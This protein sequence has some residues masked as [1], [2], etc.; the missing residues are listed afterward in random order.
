MKS[1]L[2]FQ[3]IKKDFRAHLKDLSLVIVCEALLIAILYACVAGLLMF[4]G[5][6]SADLLTQNEEVSRMFLSSGEIFL[7]CGLI[8]IINI[9][10]CYLGK[11][12]PDYMLLKR[13]GIMRK[14]LKK[15]VAFEAGITYVISLFIGLALGVLIQR[16]L[17]TIVV[18]LIDIDFQTTKVSILVFPAIAVFMLVFYGIGYLLVSELESDFLLI[19]NSQETSRIEKLKGRFGIPKIILGIFLCIFSAFSY[20]KIYNHEAV[21]LIILFFIGIYLVLRNIGAYILLYIKN[22]KPRTYYR[23]LL[24]NNKL[25]YRPNTTTRYILFFSFVGF[26]AYSFFGFQAVSIKNAISTEN[27]YPYDFVCVSNDD[28]KELFNTL[29]MDYGASVVEYPMV[30]V[31]SQ[32]KTERLEMYREKR[33]QGQQIGISETTYHQ[34]KQRLD[35]SYQ[36]SSLGL[37]ENGKSVYIV[38]QQDSYT[39]AQPVD[40]FYNMKTPNLHIGIVSPNNDHTSIN[41]T[42]FD[43][44]VVGEEIGSLIGVYSTTK[45][46]NIIVFSEEYFEKAKT[47]WENIDAPTGLEVDDFEIV[48]WNNRLP[49]FIQGPTELVLINADKD[50]IDAIDKKLESLEEEHDLIANYDS[51][52]KFH[53]SSKQAMRDL[54]TEKAIKLTI[55]IYMLCTLQ[56]MMWILL[57]SM[58]QLERNEKSE[59]EIFLS[60][61]CMKDKERRVV[62]GKEWYVY[63]FIPLIILAASS[64]IFFVG[65]VKSRLY[66]DALILA[67]F[68][69]QLWLLA[70]YIA[71][72]GIYFLIVNAVMRRNFRDGK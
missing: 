3:V 28:D 18:R 17:K 46:E 52:V 31:A 37:D 7:V 63:Y 60:R 16:G 66:S 40:W 53:Y 55:S 13:M 5:N 12:I 32:D 39:K 30:R 68:I 61:M 41:N 72:N 4:R 8:L 1:S 71:L 25:Y 9:V 11:R 20:S 2:F 49:S 36:P 44:K 45:C 59:R 23:N 43:R 58:R 19:T 51:T 6:H 33:I 56:I 70:I 14:D 67:C 50:C 26:L 24:K 21:Y 48:N 15:I 35:S 47:E 38:H 69:D 22:N 65:T 62:N 54:K 57:Y 29:S 27:L 64:L 42:F 34:L 10:I